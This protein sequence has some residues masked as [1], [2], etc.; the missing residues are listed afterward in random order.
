MKVIAVKSASTGLIQSGFGLV[1]AIQIEISQNEI[2]VN[3]SI[4]RIE[5]PSVGQFGDGFVWLAE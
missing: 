4:V 5:A 3:E 2:A 1:Q